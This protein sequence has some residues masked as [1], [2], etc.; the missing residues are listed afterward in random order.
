MNVA[1]TVDER[2]LILVVDDE[3]ANI[4]VLV[5][6]L[7]DKYRVKVACDGKKALDIV[8][9]DPLPDLILLDIMMPEMDGFAVCRRLKDDPK[10]QNIPVIF[11][12]AK[13]GSRDEEQGLNLGAIDY[14]T[15]PFRVSTIQARVHNHIIKKQQIDDLF[16]SEQKIRKITALTP[17]CIF[18]L[19]S[20]T[21]QN[22]SFPFISAGVA[23]IYG[24]SAKEAEQSPRIIVNAVI[25][26]DSERFKDSFKRALQ[27]LTRWQ[28]EYRIHAQDG[29]IKWLYAEASPK[30]QTDESIDWHGFVTDISE[31]KQSEIMLR[32]ATTVLNNMNEGV[33]VTD[34][35]NRIIK[36]N[37]SF[38]AITGYAPEDVVG[39]NPNMFSS[40][41]HPKEFYTNLWDTLIN[42][43]SWKGEICNRRKNGELYFEW[44]SISRVFDEKGNLSH[45]VGVSSDISERKAAEEQVYYLAHYDSLTELPNRNLLTDRLKQCLLGAKR[46]NTRLALMFLDI[47]NFK[48]VNDT[49]GHQIGDCLLKEV[50]SRLRNAIRATDT[51]SRIGGDEFIVL[52]PN[53]EKIS[54]VFNIA[55]KVLKSIT[56]PIA[57]SE[58]TLNT[59]TSIGIAI[60]PDHGDD[61]RLLIKHADIAMYYAKKSGRNNAKIFDEDML[62]S[63]ARIVK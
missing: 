62:T 48:Q 7:R 44:L 12:T 38:T 58:N 23:N 45:Y 3:P 35:D 29:Q 36:I 57:L 51:V 63:V 26:E 30:P 55:E 27:S 56:Q 2:P 50:A 19:K 37:S 34:A 18:Q 31:R 8:H 42:T 11:I 28:C 32:L 61:D 39:R 6:V 46:E 24:V 20:D 4:A 59:S 10:T 41:I 40:G 49:L 60:Y 9:T 5:G 43:G 16:E 25:E 13:T 33:L 52:I 14:I 54:D 15:K 17:G 47:D 1:N 53:I 22:I 21:Q